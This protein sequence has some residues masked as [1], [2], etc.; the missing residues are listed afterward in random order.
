LQ[1]YGGYQ[2]DNI[3]GS[4]WADDWIVII[5]FLNVGVMFAPYPLRVNNTLS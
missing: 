1:D 5:Y 4:L 2:A 3:D